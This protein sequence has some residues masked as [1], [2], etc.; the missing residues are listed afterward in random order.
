[1]IRTGGLCHLARLRV[2]HPNHQALHSSLLSPNLY[3]QELH[4]RDQS[5]RSRRHRVVDRG[6]LY[7]DLLMSA[8]PWLLESSGGAYLYQAD[9][10]LRGRCGAKYSDGYCLAGAA[11]AH[12]SGSPALDG[13]EDWA[14]GDVLDGRIVSAGSSLDPHLIG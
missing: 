1:M 12:D 10:I 14:H 13:S 11:C 7:A 2:R 3:N 4:P 8:R 5:H 9:T 6:G